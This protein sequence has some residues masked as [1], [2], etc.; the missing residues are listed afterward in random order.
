L[1][2]GFASVSPMIIVTM[3]LELPAAFVAVIVTGKTPAVEG[4]PRTAELSITSPGGR[5]LA[6]TLPLL[7]DG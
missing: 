2:S 6:V 3:M 7:A 4:V 1:I 5:P